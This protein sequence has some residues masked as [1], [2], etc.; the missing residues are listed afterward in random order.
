[1]SRIIEINNF[2]EHEAF[3]SN[4][5]RGII[6]FGSVRCSHCRNITPVVEKLSVQYPSIRF[7][8]VEVTEVDV[9]NIKGVPV[10]V[11]YKM[12]VP[13][14]VAI[15]PNAKSLATWVETKLL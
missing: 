6:F 5:E 4:N 1:M 10:F 8:H 13:I 2:D 15:G 3:I 14:D 9:E 11:A 12:Q 7:G